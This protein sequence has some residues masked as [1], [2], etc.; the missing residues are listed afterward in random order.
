MVFAHLKVGVF[1]PSALFLVISKSSIWIANLGQRLE[2]S[3]FVYSA[4]KYRVKTA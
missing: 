2:E 1:S 3:G 4:G